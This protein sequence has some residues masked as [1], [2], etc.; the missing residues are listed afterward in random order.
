MATTVELDHDPNLTTLFAKA[1]LRQRATGAT[2]PD[3]VYSRIDVRVDRTHL[4]AYD[5]VCG[6]RLRGLKP[7][8]RALRRRRFLAGWPVASARPSCANPRRS[9]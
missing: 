8:V 2:L 7:G 6:F 1:A 5:R 3:T 9:R 4:S